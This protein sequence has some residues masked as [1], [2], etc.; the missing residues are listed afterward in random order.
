M[1]SFYCINDLNQ[2]RELHHQTAP[3]RLPF[4]LNTSAG[5]NGHGLPR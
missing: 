5:V 3:P 4:T 1:T 2:H